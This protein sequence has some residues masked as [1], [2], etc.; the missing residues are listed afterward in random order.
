MIKTL[1]LKYYNSLEKR[2][3]F[4]IGLL[5][6]F[7]VV[8]VALNSMPVKMPF[9][10]IL[11]LSVIV[12]S[13]IFFLKPMRNGISRLLLLVQSIW[14]F[15]LITI[16]PQHY[17]LGIEALMP[18]GS[19]WASFVY[20][21][22]FGDFYIECIQWIRNFVT[23]VSQADSQLYYMIFMSIVTISLMGIIMEM[24][25]KR[26]DWKF[27]ILVGLY[28]IAAWFMYISRLQF[29][30]SIYFVG[31][32]V[33]KQFGVY[34][35]VIREAESK[36]E[37]TR[38]YNYNSAVT[39][40]GVIMII[41]LL[42]ANI[43]TRFIPM[44]ELNIK[45]DE[46]VPDV[47]NIRTDFLSRGRSNTFSFSN[48]IYM[49]NGRDLG[50]PILERDYSVVMRVRAE[51]G[52][53]YLRG[54][55][56]NIYTGKQWKSDYNTYR[57]NVFVGDMHI[58]IPKEEA[59]EMT[60]Y[61]EHI[62]TRTIF[63]PHMFYISS[64]KR[65]DVYGNS[66]QIVYIKDEIDSD[67]KSY[68]VVYV[69]DEFI[70]QYDV[71]E[72]D[73]RSNYLAVPKDGLDR[74]RALTESIVQGIE[75]P[76]DKVKALEEYLRENY[77]YT[78]YT[79]AAD[80]EMD[81]VE[82]FL[83]E[84]EMGYCTYFATSLAVMGRIADVPT[85]YIEGYIT[86]DFLDDDNLYEVTANRAHAWVEAYIE[87][88]GWV[89]FEATPAYAADLDIEEETD[90]DDF[91]LLNDVDVEDDLTVIPDRPDQT[92]ITTDGSET[93]KSIPTD[94]IVRIVVY[95]SIFILIAYLIYRKKKRIKDDI[96]LGTTTEKVYKRI[97]YMLSMANLVNDEFEASELPKDVLFRI[98][99]S[100]IDIEIPPEVAFMIDYSL[101]SLH[102]FS[103]EE[104]ELF[105]NF[106]NI[107]EEAIS[108][109]ISK[110]GHFM[111][112][113]IFN[114]LYHRDYYQ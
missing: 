75:N 46:Y 44:Q 14:F 9:S 93:K 84:E 7:P 48:T 28:F 80:Y 68:N 37:R 52:G 71:L 97:G 62:K 38:Y 86:N 77:V 105:E 2:A 17:K 72:E 12:W 78:L 42:I 54:R 1:F 81:F 88:R 89:K 99:K 110:I 31:L 102:E 74:T 100:Y 69:K 10:K 36:G 43:G 5:L 20:E 95:T 113:Y 33:Y 92:P 47:A 90:E 82:H 18:N 63:S 60:V 66:D 22:M 103:E 96:V 106:F 104:F 87:G 15:G 51:E 70:G 21:N 19:K 111:H 101:Y 55:S 58:Q 109:K 24:V 35:D 16:L 6:S 23:E 107:Y 32:T 39:V 3:V 79:E 108:S 45:I 8:L 57:N 83:F 30:F 91:E 61:P 56:K 50:G 112:K 53:L 94:L 65:T 76:Y 40:G 67:Y 85:R 41:I 49:P 34:E 26:V 64:Y 13:I 59:S 11:Y 114:T 98:C 25:E 27:F 29:Y 4:F 73:D